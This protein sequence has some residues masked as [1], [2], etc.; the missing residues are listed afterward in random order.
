MKKLENSEN[1]FFT[2]KD[3]Q[4][5]LEYENE[6]KKIDNISKI[7]SY[8]FLIISIVFCSLISFAMINTDGKYIGEAKTY[9]FAGVPGGYSSPESVGAFTSA[10]VS[11]KSV[12]ARGPSA[13]GRIYPP[14]NSQFASLFNIPSA[15][16]TTLANAYAALI[17]DINDIATSGA[18]PVVVGNVSQARNG[19]QSGIVTV[20]VGNVMDVQRRRKNQIRESYV[21]TGI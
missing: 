8:V 19:S 1:N 13:N 6:I 14:A 15:R 11:F 7:Y 5:S 20:R 17:G 18:I 9:Y 16:Q 3:L 2:N 4:N 10:A 21:E 12:I